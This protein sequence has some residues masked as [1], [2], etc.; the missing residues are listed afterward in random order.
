[1]SPP[2]PHGPEAL[3]SAL[4]SWGGWQH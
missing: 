4:L 3:H 2:A 1:L